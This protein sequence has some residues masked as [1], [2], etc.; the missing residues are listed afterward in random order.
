MKFES[1]FRN[2]LQQITDPHLW[3][4]HFGQDEKDILVF[5]SVSFNKTILNTCETILKTRKVNK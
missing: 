3:L 5:S 1:Y 4:C 2:P